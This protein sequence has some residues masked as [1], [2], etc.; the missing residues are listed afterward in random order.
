M[1]SMVIDRRRALV[2]GAILLTAGALRPAWAAATGIEAPVY[3]S[4][5]RL[6]D[7]HYALALLDAA[8]NLCRQ[9]PIAGRAHD[10]AVSPATGQAV[11]FAR[12]PGEFALAFAPDGRRE[13]VLFTPPESRCFFG[14]GA[15][16]PD[17]RLL[18]ATENDLDGGRGLLGVY[19][20]TGGFK[21]IGEIETGGVGPHEVI[22]LSDGRTL[23]VANGGYETLP[24][25]G[26]TPIDLAA[27][28]PSLVFISRDTGEIVA[29]HEPPP[30]RRLL[31]IRH[32]AEDARGRVWFGGQWEG[33]AGDVPEVIGWTR[34]DEAL[35]TFAAPAATGALLKG[36]IGSVAASRDRTTIAV[37]APRAGRVL[38]IDAAA[39]A[40]SR[41]LELPDA[42]GLAPDETQGI[43]I[44]T[45]FGKLVDSGRG[46]SADPLAEHAGIAFDNHLRRIAE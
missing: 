14:H 6:P 15:F 5:C 46:A 35:R 28:K 3:A 43:T 20:A 33:G 44:S 2:G 7:G 23:A 9:I 39:T 24:V 45:G 30:D 13:P 37:S 10:V 32:L 25:T 36:Y 40:L 11:L 22:L 34:P 18:Y 19:D 38:V 16:S 42:C 27:M 12:Q 17:G 8:G 4:A 26:R 41:V 1:S 29:R 21:R 31:S